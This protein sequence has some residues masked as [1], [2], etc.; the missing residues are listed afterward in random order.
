M[1]SHRDSK[2][3]ISDVLSLFDNPPQVEAVFQV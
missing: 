2:K 1:H 3:N